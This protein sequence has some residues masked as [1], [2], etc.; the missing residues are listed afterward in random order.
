MAKDDYG[1]QRD[2][3]TALGISQPAVAGWVKRGVIKV[4]RNGKIHIPTAIAAVNAAR[5]PER[6]LVGALSNGKEVEGSPADVSSSTGNI[7]PH[8]LMRARTVTAT[9]AAQQQ[10]LKLK[11]LQGELIS[12]ADARL[13]CMAVVTEI[14]TRLEGLP[15]Q[16]APVVHAAETVAEAEAM[17]RGMVRAVLVEVAKLGEAVA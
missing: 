15:G 5:D 13:A 10:Q 1:T 9:L 3:A 6:A 11:Q 8:A 2:V 12:K 17:L 7:G 14:K 16:A 4:A